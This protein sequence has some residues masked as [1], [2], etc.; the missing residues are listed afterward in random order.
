MPGNWNSGRRPQPNALKMLRGNPGK[1]RL[2][3]HEPPLPRATDAFDTPPSELNH[4]P[5][6]RSEWE[7]LAPLLRQ[8]GLVSSAD[9]N[10][11]L[12]LCQ[13]WARYLDAH[14]KVVALG[15]VVKA[16]DGSPM[17]NPFWPIANDALSHCR[18]LWV[19]LGL[20]PSSRSR[21][22]A[23]PAIDLAPASRWEGFL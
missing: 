12:A 17:R 4:D 14:D 18:Q 5:V 1:R 2:N 20:T 19:E 21:I 3:A 15:M 23:L 10:A 22:S 16:S 6:A 7:R 13:Q 11:L 8:C 9:R